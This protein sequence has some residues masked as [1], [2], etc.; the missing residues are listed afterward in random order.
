MAGEASLVVKVQD[1]ALLEAVVALKAALKNPTPAYKKVGAY[2]EKEVNIR[3]DTKTGPDGTAWQ[4]WAESTQEARDKEGRGTLLEYTGRMRDSFTY[5]ANEKGVDVGFG[6]IYALFHE[7]GAGV[8]ARPMLLDGGKLA[9]QDEAAVFA[10]L[11][12]FIK[13]APLLNGKTT[14]NNKSAA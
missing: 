5:N 2:F 3:F 12:R 11:Q 7:L 13:N 8:P 9:T 1:Y 4:K 14:N 6:V 10:I